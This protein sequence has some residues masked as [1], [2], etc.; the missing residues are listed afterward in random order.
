MPRDLGNN[1]E[2]LLYKRLIDGWKK[3]YLDI[4]QTDQIKYSIVFLLYYWLYD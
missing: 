3:G 4:F 1:R 2:L